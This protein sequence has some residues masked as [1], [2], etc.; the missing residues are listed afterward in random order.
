LLHEDDFRKDVDVISNGNKGWIAKLEKW[1][2][3]GF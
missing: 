2:Q 1:T 3:G